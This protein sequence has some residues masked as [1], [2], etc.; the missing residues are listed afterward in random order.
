MDSKK[1]KAKKGAFYHVYS[2]CELTQ[3]VCLTINEVGNNLKEVLKQKLAITNEGKCIPQGFIRPHSIQVQRYSSGQINNNWIEFQVV[4]DCWICYP[5]EGQTLECQVKS[6]TK[7]GIHAEVVVTRDNH[8]S[9]PITVFVA[10]DHHI[11]HPLYAQVKEM[12]SIVVTVIGARFE[13]NDPFICVI[14][15]LNSIVSS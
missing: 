2:E 12:S 8:T 4:F 3:K 10:R 7:A 11:A 13:L 14:A 1:E 5:Y 6:V 9:K 15:E